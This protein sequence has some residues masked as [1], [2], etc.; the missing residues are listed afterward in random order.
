ME[1]KIFLQKKLKISYTYP[2]ILHVQIIGV[3]SEKFGEE[4]MPWVKLRP[5]TQVSEDELLQY[6]KG[7]IAHYKIL[8]YWKFVEE[9]P[10]TI[11]GKVRKVEIREVSIK[12]LGLVKN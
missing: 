6:C 8:K 9:F 3:P 7:Q 10:M 12:E 11:C 4:V 1:E 2:N 5:G